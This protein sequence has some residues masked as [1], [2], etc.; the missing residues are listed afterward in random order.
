MKLKQKINHESNKPIPRCWVTDCH[1]IVAASGP[2]EDLV[3]HVT[4]PQQRL[5]FA[6]T[7]NKAEVKKLIM[8]H[9]VEVLKK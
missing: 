3:Y 9:K 1:Y 2:K 5:P 8:A 7:Q 6:Y 4:A